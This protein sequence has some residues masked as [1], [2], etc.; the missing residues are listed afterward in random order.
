MKTKNKILALL[1]QH[2][3]ESISGAVIAK[4]LG[5]TR[6]T[7]WKAVAALR[8]EGY[9]ISS[10]NKR[11]YTLSEDN[12]ILSYESI[13]PYLCDE[14][15]ASRFYLFKC[16]ESTNKTAK[17]M[18]AN[19]CA[20]G[21]I[22]MADSQTQG[23]G[24]YGRGFYSPPGTG[25]YMSFVFNSPGLYFQNPSLITASAAV[26]VCEAIEAVS[27]KSATIKWVNDILLNGKKVCGILT[28]AMTDVETG[29]FQWVVLGI[30]INV[31]HKSFP[32]DIQSFAGS[33]YDEGDETQKGPKRDKLAAEIINRCL[34]LKSWLEDE[35]LFHKYKERSAI[36][37]EKITVVRQNEQYEAKALD[38]NKDGS[39]VVKKENG[40]VVAVH[41]AEVSVKMV[42]KRVIIL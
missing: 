42:S 8:E 3:G 35:S 6:A 29:N 1:E 32:K 12:D 7:V 24:R 13:A 17:E 26:A 5:L 15:I 23:K 4:E 34:P 20:H 31:C 18:A 25:L 41:S 11:G 28:E 9:N 40:E 19:G 14:N 22:I 36:L 21:T 39:L 2:R 10:A 37:G 33:V 38:I 16:L 27:G 30:G